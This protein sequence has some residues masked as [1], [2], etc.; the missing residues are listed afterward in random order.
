M[1]QAKKDYIINTVFKTNTLPIISECNTSCVFC[2]HKQNPEG[3]DVFRMPKLKLDDFDEIMEYISPGSKIIIGESATRIIEGE[4]LL[5]KDFTAILD[6][7][8]KKNTDAVI[9]IT[10]NGILLDKTLINSL[11]EL[12]GIE[13]NIS[14]N[15]VDIAKRKKVLGLNIKNDIR[16]AIMMLKDKLRFS[17]SCVIVPDILKWKD[18]EEMIKLLDDNN[19]DIAR[20]Y[21]PGYTK[22]SKMQVD[23]VKL[24]EEM[25]SF[26]KRMREKY[27]IPIMLEPSFISDFECRIEGI[28]KNSPAHHAGLKIGDIIE[29]INNEEV[30]TRV[31]AFNK[32]YNSQNPLLIIRRC[33]EL[34]QFEVIKSKNSSPG[35]VTLYDIDPLILVP[36]R[37][38]IKRYRASNVLFMT[39]ELAEKVL[40][41]LILISELSCEYR[42]INVKNE[43]FG[44]TIK[45]AGLLTGQD[46][47]LRAKEYFLKHEKPDLIILPP[48]MFDFRGKDLIGKTIDQIEEELGIKVVV[49]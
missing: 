28:L 14:I 13:L 12:G 32:I 5:H 8:R 23:F 24:Y 33:E 19:A 15:C 2:S 18:F 36:I 31:Q 44:G 29:K 48:I 38:A 46:I 16:P 3:L 11:V 26:V 43:F 25:S 7:I 39:S 10:T 4:P 47:I 35:F 21:L 1:Q 34:I 9:Q 30:L 45:C 49:P 22:L 20:L 41:K 17:G 37:Q 42:I 40:S 6:K 27:S